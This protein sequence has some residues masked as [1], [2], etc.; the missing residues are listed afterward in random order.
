MKRGAECNIDL[1]MLK[2]KLQFARKSFR[3]GCSKGG[4]RKF[5]MVKLSGRCVDQR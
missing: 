4:E 1:M 3:D 5:D 2:V